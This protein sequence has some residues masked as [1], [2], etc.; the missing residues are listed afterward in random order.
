[1]RWNT[2]SLSDADFSEMLPTAD[3][4]AGAARSRHERRISG[5]ALKL[6]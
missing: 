6:S 2:D 1:L 3:F 5:D 4:V